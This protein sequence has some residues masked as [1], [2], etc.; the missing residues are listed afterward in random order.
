MEAVALLILLVIL[1]L[2]IA[3]ICIAC[4]A[5][6]SAKESREQLRRMAEELKRLRAEVED[7]RSTAGTKPK[8]TSFVEQAPSKVCDLPQAPIFPISEPSPRP[9]PIRALSAKPP[10]NWEQFLGVKLFAWAGGLALFFGI[11]FFVKY[12]FDRNLIPP[13]ARATI[14]YIVA[15]GL[16]VGSVRVL[17]SA[18]YRVLGQSL[19]ASGIVSLYGVTFAC[20]A[21]YRFP[22]FG[23]T[24]TAF[25][26]SAITVTAFLLAV[27]MPTQVVA[28]LGI[29]GGFLTPPLVS[30][31]QDRFFA[32]F[33]FIGFLDLGILA[34]TRKTRWHYLVPLAA[35]GTSALALG[36]MA[37]FFQPE[38][39]DLGIKT[40]QP[41]A[42][43]L[44]FA[45]LFV[46]FA[47]W[48]WRAGE[49]NGFHVLAAVLV[50]A[51]GY[52]AAWGMSF[53]ADVAT[54][55]WLLLGFVL[56]ICLLAQ[57][58][59]VIEPLPTIG[60]ASA[61]F[62]MLFFASWT[63]AWL[64]PKWLIPTLVMDLL[65][66]SSLIALPWLL[67]RWR[68][69]SDEMLRQANL[70]PLATSVLLYLPVTFA[71]STSFLI[72][73]AL[74]FAVLLGVVT[75]ARSRRL[76]PLAWTAGLVL[77]GANHWM[78]RLD[79]SPTEKWLSFLVVLTV[80][81]VLFVLAT[82]WLGKRL[83]EGGELSKLDAQLA[84][85]LPAA[86][87]ASPFGLIL[88]ALMSVPLG[89]P[90]P[91][92]AVAA[93]FLVILFFLAR[94]TD[95]PWLFLVG[96]AALVVVCWTWHGL[97][98][99]PAR[100]W[101][102]LAWNIAF[103][104]IFAAL[105]FVLRVFPQ[106]ILPWAAAACSGVA[107]FPMVHDAIKRAFP[108]EVMGLVP[109]AFAIP[110]L[111]SL[112]AVSKEPESSPTRLGKLSWFGGAALFFITLVFPIQWERH[113][114]TVG[115]ALEGAALAWLHRRL[116]HRGLWFTSLGL[117]A[118]VFVRLTLNPALI[119]YGARGPIPIWNWHLYTYG[120]AA[121]SC[122][123]AAHWLHGSTS[124]WPVFRPSA[125]LMGLGGVLLFLLL[126]IEIADAFAAPGERFAF[127]RLQNS[128]GQDM[129]YSIGWA[130]FALALMVLGL[131]FRAR[132]ARLAG[133][134]LLLLTLGKLFLYDLSTISQGYRI[135]AFLGVALA[136]LGASF[137]YQRAAKAADA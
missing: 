103:L 9:E 85:I 20:H 126:N 135:M 116:G 2:L 111:L 108:N 13:S 25:V 134:G 3:P 67:Q 43:F 1:L 12:A 23:A 73:P 109:A 8:D 17:R 122:F 71:K 77:L 16:V 120:L 113:W 107:F 19:C 40:L 30:T 48:R 21:H 98:F 4:F 68:A 60:I 51:T 46:G 47:L 132:P 72:W 56:A 64:E 15:V 24:T 59:G 10:V 45:A 90:S 93:A 6:G 118:A 130:M 49:A 63:V 27:R 114:I 87:G 86:S 31:G 54:R 78:K 79:F 28:I 131:R 125:C 104:A 133:I 61:A 74:L 11:V 7:L 96:Q 44:L 14:G 18:A 95:Q 26:M 80:F 34:V 52:L 129:T 58:T 5:H 124:P 117:L 91:A 76:G 37:K 89:N 81:G 127:F 83:H 36:W 106:S 32:L 99:D 97:N 128:L 84:K 42:V 119:H 33:S 94:G 105:P 137:V 123:A 115:W 112:L 70:V 55:P 66:G 38:H 100:P 69:E 50:C 102:G 75:A 110:P 22:L 53:D 88:F 65:A 92:Y 29:L 35:V 57:S 62:L 82:Q 101:M 136:A 39:Y 41:C 121:L